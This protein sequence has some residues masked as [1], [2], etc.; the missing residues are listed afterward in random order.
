M[1]KFIVTRQ[2][3]K[4]RIEIE[5]YIFSIN[6]KISDVH[7]FLDEHDRV[8]KFIENNPE[9]PAIHP[10]TGDQSWPFGNGHYRLFFRV[11]NLK[12]AFQIFLLD[13]IDNKQLNLKVYPENKIPTYTED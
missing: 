5:D 3:E 7:Q 6:Q 1:T 12:K 4:K 10:V 13:I 2:Y 9:T 8:L 11:V